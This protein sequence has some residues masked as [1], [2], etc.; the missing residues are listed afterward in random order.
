MAAI[1]L[2]LDRGRG[3][4]APRGDHRARPRR[5]GAG[6]FGARTASPSSMGWNSTSSCRG[7]AAGH[8]ARAARRVRP[9]GSARDRHRGERQRAPARGRARALRGPRRRLRAGTTSRTCSGTG[10]RRPSACPRRSSTAR[11]PGSSPSGGRPA[12]RGARPWPST[13]PPRSPRA[14]H[15][16]LLVDVD[17]YGGTIAPA[18]GPARRG[19]GLRRRLPARRCR[20][21][22]H[23]RSSTASPSATARARAP[24]GCSPASAVP[25]A[26]RSS[27]AAG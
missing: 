25:R 13:W 18:L 5:R 27:E 26:G 23:G 1:A 24:S 3:G 4:R 15:S 11:S 16:V 19:A 10:G 2:L 22:H 17:P 6:R 14:G 8:H 21:P 20:Q 12:R 9:P 7:D